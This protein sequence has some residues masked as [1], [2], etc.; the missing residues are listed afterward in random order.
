M[1]RRKP[2]L[3]AVVD[4]NV[5]AYLLLGTEPYA[6]PCERFFGSLRDGI[7][8]ATWEVELGNVIWLAARGGVL[9]PSEALARLRLSRRL[10]ITSVPPGDLCQGALLRSIHSGIAVYDSLFVEVAVRSGRRLATF[11]GALLRAFPDIAARPDDL[12]EQ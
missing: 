8:P 2:S 9:P 3:S 12:L 5:A 4:T 11:D 1:A 10:G 6:A 7:A